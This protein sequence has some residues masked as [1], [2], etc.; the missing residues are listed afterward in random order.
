MSADIKFPKE[1]ADIGKEKW[2]A[3]VEECRG[4]NLALSVDQGMAQKAELVFGLSDFVSQRCIQRPQI[5]AGL[6]ESRDLQSRYPEGAYAQKV[7][8]QCAFAKDMAGLSLFLRE[9]RIRE[10][11]RIAFRSLSGD[12]DLLET[13]K[14]LSDLADAS[15]DFTQA[16]VYQWLTAEFGTPLGKSDRPQRLV[17]IG[18]GKLGGRELNFSS[19]IDLMFAFPEAGDTDHIM[20][21]I[22]NEQFFA[23]LCQRII[24]AIGKNLTDGFVFRVDTRLRPFGDGGA[25]AQSFDAMDS[26]Y[27][28]QGREWERYALI[29]ARVIAG[30]ASAGQS[31]LERLGPFVYRRYLD[32][33]TF[34]SLRE[35][36]QKISR[37]I[38]R[39]GMQ[40]NIKL[41]AGGI[42]EIEFF[43]QVFQLIRGGINPL[44]QE[45]SILAVLRILAKDNCI[46]EE[47]GNDLINA[48]IFLRN[49]ENRI[50]MIGDLQTH[51]LPETPLGRMRVTSSMGFDD[52]SSFT[53]ALNAVMGNVHKNFSDLLSAE[54]ACLQDNDET[55]RLNDLWECL[56]D[57]EACRQMLIKS[58]IKE[59]DDVYAVLTLFKELAEA[60]DVSAQGKKRI[61]RLVPQILGQVIST[62]EP[63]K[64][65]KRIYELMNSFRRRSC[66]AA[67]LLEN[68]DSLTHLVNLAAASSWIVS[69]LS[70]HPL[71]LD[72]LLDPRALYA[73]LNKEELKSE[74]VHRL[75][76]MAPDDLELQMDDL[77][78]FKQIN[79][80]RIAAADVSGKLSLMKV[81]D[82]LT[83]LAETIVEQVLEMSWK[84]LV[85][86]YGL[87]EG[88]AQDQTGFAI[89]AYGKLGGIE[90][91]Y[92]SDLDLVFL[93]TESKGYTTG[94][95]MGPLDN[96]QFYSRLGQRIIH[97]LTTMTRTGKL[98]EIDMRL[99]PS[100]N[101]GILVTHMDAFEEYQ[102]K[103]AWTWEH[104]ALIKARPIIGDTS[105]AEKFSAIRERILCINREKS[106]LK[107]AIHKMRDRMRKE[108]AS[109]D[110]RAFDLKHDAGG[111]IDIEFIVQFLILLHAA[112]NTEL[113]K[114]PDVVRQLNVLAL[115][116]I[117]DDRTA[118]ILK[119][120]YLV[121][122]YCVHRL[123]LEEKPAILP[124]PGERFTELRQYVHQIW[125]TYL[126]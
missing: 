30:D 112:R 24:E 78:I 119:Q 8:T 96:A 21:P 23:R 95:R 43:G 64:I 51:T 50:Q 109:Q 87:P 116:G 108:H 73:P 34:E 22:T 63:V 106:V 92:G 16:L 85:E 80:L 31:L 97:F 100:G 82:R 123:T 2:A 103:Q 9:F 58:G 120:A 60:D 29:K 5:L 44:Y 35:M 1:L 79:T 125:K 121:F 49:V 114:W 72:E 45:R 25:I 20:R 70:Q 77:R 19:D 107:E 124:L 18:V 54:D 39:K 81:S 67:L 89:I 55:R 27:R 91:G 13:M 12:S 110:P 86:K 40:G 93:Y 36:K 76:R 75:S 15:L 38:T 42:R 83:Y 104:Q 14:D 117:I 56:A 59:V 3:F 113:T 37:E 111:I 101:A 118:Y 53:T 126:E 84:N 6:V 41:G 26:Y 10:M 88:V 28:E 66:Y 47:V 122:R 115:A 68:P 99:R 65:L 57:R 71:L 61:Y 69:L 74:L 33:G 105:M 7:K 32:Y 17:V 4:K 94:G 90:L 52:W 62:E 102:I 98:Y 48:Y 11:C 46:A